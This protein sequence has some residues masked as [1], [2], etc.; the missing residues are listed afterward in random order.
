MIETDNDKK[1][2]IVL[3]LNKLMD[4]IFRLA[5]LCKEKQTNVESVVYV[6]NDGNDSIAYVY[7]YKVIQ[8]KSSSTFDKLAQTYMGDPSMGPLIAYYNKIQ[9]EHN[10]EAGTN[11]RIPILIKNGSNQENKIY[12]SPDMQDNYGRDI[13]MTDTGGFAVSPSGDFQVVMGKENLAQSLG[14]RFTTSSEKRIRLGAYGIRAAIGD[15]LA[16]NSFL[17]GSIEQTAYEDPRIDRVEDIKFQGM[18]D[19]LNIVVTYTDIN[20][21]QDTYK[22]EI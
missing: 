17:L 14:N 11:I 12:A 15:P 19:N 4:N 5:A 9:N 10:V 13:A 2:S 7:D 8:M 22:G 3:M 21:N 6:N 16:V 18:K 20:G 1:D